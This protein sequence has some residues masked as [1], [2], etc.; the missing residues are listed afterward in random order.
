MDRYRLEVTTRP[1]AVT[2]QGEQPR[3]DDVLTSDVLGTD[4]CCPG[5]R[6]RSRGS[7]D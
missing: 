6:E 5:T 1:G 3:D 2:C 7:K 4:C